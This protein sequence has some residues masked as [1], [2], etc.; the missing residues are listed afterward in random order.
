MKGG[1]GMVQDKRMDMSS[2]GD[3]NAVIGKNP[4]SRHQLSKESA[5]DRSSYFDK[6]AETPVTRGC[7]RSEQLF[8]F[9]FHHIGWRKSIVAR[10]LGRE[11]HYNYLLTVFLLTTNNTGLCACATH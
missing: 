4:G 3:F 5:M 8:T 9:H 2:M 1:V 10:L 6:V 11:T 7:P